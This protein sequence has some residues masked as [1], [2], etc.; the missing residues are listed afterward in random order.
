MS[1]TARI[2]HFFAVVAT[3]TAGLGGILIWWAVKTSGQPP[4]PMVMRIRKFFMRFG[5]FGILLTWISGLIVLFA[6]Y[7]GW[8]SDP[9][10]TIKIS[11]AAALLLLII[12]INMMASKAAKAGTPPPPSLLPLSL[13]AFPLL[14]GALVFAVIT[15]SD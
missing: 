11:L 7:G 8:V 1:E 6:G 5:L 13:S 12:V 14:F 9:N 2:L 3:G 15:F 4:H 10:F